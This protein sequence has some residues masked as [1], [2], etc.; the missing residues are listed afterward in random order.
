MCIFIIIIINYNVQTQTEYIK[1]A[2]SLHMYNKQKVR[3][4]I[5]YLSNP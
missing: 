3:T 5:T 1:L 2:K 4:K